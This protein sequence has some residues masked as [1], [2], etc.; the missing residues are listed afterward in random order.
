K[1][2]QLQ[3]LQ[4]SLLPSADPAVRG[5]IAAFRPPMLAL[6]LGAAE[7]TPDS[8]PDPG[9]PPFAIGGP[10]DPDPVHAQNGLG[11][12]ADPDSAR[13]AA[14]QADELLYLQQTGTAWDRAAYV[15]GP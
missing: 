9:P 10:Y 1:V 7:P 5:V 11:G 6:H 2:S 12:P 14:R 4:W 13:R 3:A 15:K 8:A